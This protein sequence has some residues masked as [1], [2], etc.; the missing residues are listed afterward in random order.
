MRHRGWEA[1]R[2]DHP[3]RHGMA[4]QEF[5]RSVGLW[6]GQQLSSLRQHAATP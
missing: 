6:R 2:E 4:D 5:V 3:A 1:L